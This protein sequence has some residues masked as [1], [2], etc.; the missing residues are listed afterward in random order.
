MKSRSPYQERNIN[1]KN[2]AGS[3][4]TIAIRRPVA[5]TFASAGN[6]SD[7]SHQ[8]SELRVISR[9][10]LWS[11]QLFLLVSCA[12]FLIRDFNLYETLPESVLQILGCP[13]PPTLTHVA[14]AGYI[15]T[16]LTPLAIHLLNGG[17]PSAQWRHLGYRSM[18][19]LFYLFSNTLTANFMVVFAIGIVLYLLEQLS[20]CV[21]IMRTDQGDG[22]VA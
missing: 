3:A 13:P 2:R 19:Y 20:I 17:K 22:Q 1:G 4:A 21:S 11:L 14:L 15:F 18:F 8:L 12:A 6:D 9:H 5:K 7:G 16:V 10:S